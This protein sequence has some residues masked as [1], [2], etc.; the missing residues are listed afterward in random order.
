MML[1]NLAMG[2]VLVAIVLGLFLNLQV[3]RWAMVG[4]P[5][6][7]LGAIWLMPINPYPVTVNVQFVRLYYGAGYCGGR[8]HCYW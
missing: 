4:I 7:F 1:S 6:S 8:C 2:A 5:V 3:A